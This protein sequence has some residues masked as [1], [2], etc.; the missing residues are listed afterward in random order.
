MEKIRSGNNGWGKDVERLKKDGL[1]YENRLVKNFV[2]LSEKVT[3]IEAANRVLVIEE[4]SQLL[5]SVK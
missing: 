5:N 2:E 4:I 1:V 3:K